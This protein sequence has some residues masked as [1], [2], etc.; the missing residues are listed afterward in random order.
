MNFDKNLLRLIAW[1]KKHFI[2]GIAAGVF[3][4]LLTILQSKLISIT[5]DSVFLKNG[6]LSTLTKVI[7]LFALVSLIK[8][9]SVWAQKYFS[10]KSAEKIK[11][12]LRDLI[13]QKIFRLGPAYTNEAQSG[14]INNTIT[15]GVDKLDAYFRQYL[16]QVFLSALVPVLILI[17]VFPIDWLS[18]TVFLITAPVIPFF[19]IMIGEKASKLS[20]KQWKTLTFLSSHFFD[21]IQGLTTLKLFGRSKD[22][23]RKISEISDEFRKTTLGVLKVAF[24]S[25]LVLELLSTISI[26]IVSVEIGLRLLYGKIEF[27]DAFFVLLLAP[28]FYLPLRLLGS[29][30]HAGLDG[31]TASKSIFEIIDKEEIESKE[32]T[33]HFKKNNNFTIVFDNVSFRYGVNLPALNKVSF[34]IK[35]NERVALVGKSGAGKTTIINLLL[36]FLVPSEGKI[37]INGTDL[38]LI[39]RNQWLEHVASLSQTPYLFSKSIKEN[40]MMG[41]SEATEKEVQIAA[42]F[43]GIHKFIIS[44]PEGYETVISEKGDSLSGGQAQRIALARAFLKNAPILILDE[45]TANLDPEIEE[46][47]EEKI[48][49][50]AKN[51]TTITIAHRLNTIRRADKIIVLDQGEIKEVGTHEELIAAGG[52]YLKFLELYRGAL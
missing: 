23:I 13:L 11:S 39:P 1:S 12:K 5:I 17:F 9:F 6:T 31:V 19:M 42:E 2:A 16:P 30:F 48:N 52:L 4:A 47:I 29:G 24:L 51:K 10:A 3:I 46:E 43:A 35:P 7:L 44:L 15:E 20:K 8:S 22:Q 41:K 27:V 36:K 38:S 49:E 33:I 32:E 26:A 34:V 28:E 40:I 37:L 25:A 45:P 14:E 50:L 18:G 21:V